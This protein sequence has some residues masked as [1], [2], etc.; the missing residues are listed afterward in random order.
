M[1][2]VPSLPSRPP[3]LTAD[4]GSEASTTWKPPFWNQPLRTSRTS[5]SSS[6]RRIARMGAPVEGGAGAAGGGS[7]GSANEASTAAVELR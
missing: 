6:T 3:V 1:N 2:G 7:S 5:S 4:S